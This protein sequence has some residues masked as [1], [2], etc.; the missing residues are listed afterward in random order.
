MSRVIS[1]DSHAERA[2]FEVESQHKQSIRGDVARAIVEGG[3]DLNE[4]RSSAAS[5][6]EIFLQLTEEQKEVQPE[7]AEVPA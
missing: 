2:M 6:E 7:S 1:K 4:L 3:W 5:L